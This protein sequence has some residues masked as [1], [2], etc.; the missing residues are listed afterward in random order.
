MRDRHITD[1]AYMTQNAQ[2]LLSPARIDALAARIDRTRAAPWGAGR[3]PADT[4]W[5][6]VI[7]GAGR[8]V[9]FIQSLY[10]EYG[11]GVV[12]RESG[13]NWQNR[14]CSF[15]LDERALNAL[16]PG[17]KPFHTL[18]PALALLGDGTLDGVRQHGRRWA[19]AD[20]KRG[21]HALRDLR[22]GSAGRHRRPAL[23]A[24]AHM[25]PDQRYAEARTSLRAALSSTSCGP[26]GTTSN[27]SLR[28]TRRSGMPA[29]SCGMRMACWR[30]AATR[31]RTAVS[32][33][34]NP[35]APGPVRRRAA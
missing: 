15:S 32:P 17:R 2:D 1:P 4:V 35:D 21:V 20:A 14:G 29:R 19:A 33:P 18:N 3:M 7:D 9:S 26:A 30:A 8:A 31:A 22:H 10:H 28:T 24:R 25:G 13:I 11:A 5:M 16:R 6:G 23:A 27:C 12:L 34:G